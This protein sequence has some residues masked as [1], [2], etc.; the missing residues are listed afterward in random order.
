M[1]KMVKITSH[2]N[3]L[4]K[5]LDEQAESGLKECGNYAVQK[6]KGYCPVDTGKLRDSI[7]FDVEDGTLR[8]YSDVEYAPYVELGTRNQRAQPFLS[9]AME[10]SAE[11][12]KILEDALS[13]QGTQG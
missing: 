5:A 1:R 8:L 7:D 9:R 4:M 10:D 11:F 12:R 6:A 13:G 2:V 3:E